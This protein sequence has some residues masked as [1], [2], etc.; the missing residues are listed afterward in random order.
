M[1]TPGAVIITVLLVIVASLTI[2]LFPEIFDLYTVIN[3]TI[4]ASMGILTLSLALVWGYCGIISL[5][6]FFWPD[7]IFRLGRLH[8]CGGGH[9]FWRFNTG[10]RVSFDLTNIICCPAW[11]FHLLGTSD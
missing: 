7:R 10:D 1:N 8:L 11:L 3:A 9:Q 4:Y 6:Y 2:W 5:H